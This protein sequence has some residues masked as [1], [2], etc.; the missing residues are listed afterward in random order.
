M[1]RIADFI[2]RSEDWHKNVLKKRDQLSKK[3]ERERSQENTFHPRIN[4]VSNLLHN[5]K[6][7]MLGKVNAAAAKLSP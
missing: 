3:L 6:L 4:Q 7:N 5:H 2:E 1:L